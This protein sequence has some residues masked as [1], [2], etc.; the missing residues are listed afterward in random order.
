MASQFTS[1]QEKVL[2]I[3][4]KKRLMR[5]G[6]LMRAARI[7]KPEEFMEIVIPLVEKSLVSVSGDPYDPKGV[8][9]ARFHI[10]PTELSYLKR[11]V[12]QM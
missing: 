3:L 10:R 11:M 8:L 7:K 1:D 5:G 6:S 2:K 12:R 9:S 4:I